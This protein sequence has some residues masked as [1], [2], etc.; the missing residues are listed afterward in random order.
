[1][2]FQPFFKKSFTR[3]IVVIIENSHCKVCSCV[4]SCGFLLHAGITVGRDNMIGGGK[5]E[6]QLSRILL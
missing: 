4:K 1:M 2:D 3:Y 6:T 5:N